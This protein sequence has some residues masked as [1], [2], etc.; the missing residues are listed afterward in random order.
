MNGVSHLADKDAF[1]V[2]FLDDDLKVDHVLARG[3]CLVVQAVHLPPSHSPVSRTQ[4]KVTSRFKGVQ[5]ELEKL[6]LRK[7]A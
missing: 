5:Q 7:S 4:A 1:L 6:A 3:P 2:G